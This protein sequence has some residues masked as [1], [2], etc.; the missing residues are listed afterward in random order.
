MVQ[1]G[2]F[3]ADLCFRLNLVLFQLPRSANAGAGQDRIR[4]VLAAT[5]GE[6]SRAAKIL[7]IERDTL[8]RKLDRL[9]LISRTPAP[10]A[11]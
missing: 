2:K 11:P 6:K 10:P 3:R 4:N 1:D 7:G 8:Y 9:D 5:N